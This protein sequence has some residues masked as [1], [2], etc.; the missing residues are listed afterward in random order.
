VFILASLINGNRAV[1]KL[2]LSHLNESKRKLLFSNEG[3]EMKVQVLLDGLNHHLCLANIA[4]TSGLTA[5][6][7]RLEVRQLLMY[8]A[9][10]L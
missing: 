9:I 10:I 2:V 8:F 1:A 6:L 3:E 5:N 7:Q 4:P